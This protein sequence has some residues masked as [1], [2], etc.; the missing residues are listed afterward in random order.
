MVFEGRTVVVN[1]CTL[2]VSIDLGFNVSIERHVIV[3]GIAPER[4]S[5][6]D[7]N[8]A[9]H[10]LV[11]LVGGKP[12]VLRTDPAVRGY[13]I[14]AV[15]YLNRKVHGEP[16]G[17]ER[18]DGWGTPLLNIGKFHAWLARY[19]YDVREAL[20]VLNGKAVRVG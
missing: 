10:A 12:L 7:T 16:E 9:A 4:I 6:S 14:T 20:A 15:V 5:A 2:R 17:L 19:N 11:V 8:A 18:V 13:T 1:G 3:D